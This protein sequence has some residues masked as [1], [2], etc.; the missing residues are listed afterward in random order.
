ME[1]DRFLTTR[2]L[3]HRWGDCSHM[4]IE[5][6]LKADPDMPQPDYFGRLRFFRLSKI[7]TYEAKRSTARQAEAA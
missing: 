5:R 2:Q 7:E 1:D 3:R 4:F 6:R